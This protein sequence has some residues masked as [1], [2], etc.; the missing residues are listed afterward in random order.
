MLI[1][2]VQPLEHLSKHEINPL[3][4]KENRAK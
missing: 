3:K 2:E 4:D 1:V